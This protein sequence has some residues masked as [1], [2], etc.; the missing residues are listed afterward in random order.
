MRSK[1]GFMGSLHRSLAFERNLAILFASLGV[2]LMA[3]MTG[4][5]LLVLEPNLRADAE[6]RV[7]A[8]AQAQAR[9]LEVL[10]GLDLAQ[11]RLLDELDTRINGMLLLKEPQD[12]SKLTL[13]IELELDP[14][15]AAVPPE[16]QRLARGQ[17]QCPDC[18]KV[19][20]P[21]YHPRN[22]QLIGIAT[23]YCNTASLNRLI[24][25]VRI[26]LIWAGG[27]ILALIVVAW[28][29]T[30]RL[31]L[32]LRESESNVRNL[33][34]VA[35]FPI[36]LLEQDQ[37]RIALANKAAQRYLGLVPNATGRLDSM[38][39]L[40][41]RALGMDLSGPQRREIQLNSEG[42]EQRWAILSA[43]EVNVSNA[44]HPV[45]SLVDVSELKAVQQRLHLAANT[46][47]LTKSY[48][49]R[50]LFERLEEEIARTENDGH[51]LSVILFDL[52]EFK[53][54]NDTYGH[55]VGD[56]VLIQTAEVMR[57]CIR[58]ADT[59][60]RYGGEEF[61]VILPFATRA[62]AAELAERIRVGIESLPPIRPN[63][64]L[65][66]SGGIAEHCGT[67]V[68]SLLEA[69]DRNLYLAKQ[70]GRNRVI[71]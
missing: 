23:F 62:T 14:D 32:R 51:S 4:Y 48:N 35:P 65:T 57:D 3:L 22:Q 63:L 19:D 5:W 60:G 40:R 59:C 30:V 25:D 37:R 2:L 64:K 34:D 53:A 39:W 68:D 16:R 21:L 20:A 55:A 1:R 70:Q 15:S 9:S 45:V 42:G 31:L 69:A 38:A 58:A 8:L 56:A 36:L 18:L 13:R 46:D 10:F 7:R 67:D 71:G 43:T 52:D 28:L 33:L 17:A 66:I 11:S 12:D 50:F 49:R 44:L 26:R 47:G 61:L 27:S 24:G 29:G 54:V 6:S 41:I